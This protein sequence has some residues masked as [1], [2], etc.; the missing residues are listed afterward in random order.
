[1]AVVNPSTGL[2]GVFGWDGGIGQIDSINGIVDNT[3]TI[4]LSRAGTIDIRLSDGQFTI[5]GDVFTLYIDG[6]LVP[7]TTTYYWGSDNFNGVLEDFLLS[8]GTHTVTAF[9]SG[10]NAYGTITEFAISAVTYVNAPPSAPADGD[11]SAGATVYEDH[12]V[13]T[14]IGL[15]ANSTDPDAGDTVSY[16]LGFDVRGN[17]I[18]DNG[19]FA[20][21]PSTGVVTL[22]AALDYESAASH[23]LRIYA[24]DGEGASSFTD[25]NITVLDAIEGTPG[26][27][28]LLGTPNSDYMYGYGGHDL[29]RGNAGNDQLNGGDGDDFL[30]GGLGDDVIDG[31]AGSDR[32]AFYT[33][34]TAGVTVDLNIVGPQATG[35]GN[36]T[37][38]GIEN[39]SGTPYADTLIGDGNDN[40]LWGSVSALGDGTPTGLNNDTLD[41]GGGNDLLTVGTGAHLLT[42]GTGTDTVSF[43]ENGAAEPGVTVSLELEGAAQVTGAGSWTLNGIENLSG[44]TNNDN[45]TGDGNAN[46]LAGDAGDDTL[47]GKGGNDTLYGDGQISVD[48]HG[49]G[50][51]G[52]ITTTADTGAGG[53]DTLEGGLG[54]DQLHGGGGSD[55]ATYA[56]AAGVV[57][58]FLD[59]GGYGEAYGADGYDE[60][61]DIENLTG[62]AFNDILYGNSVDNFISGGDGHD[63]VRGGA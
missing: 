53:N 9:V 6:V 14:P 2:S 19:Q 31:G 63:D 33:D 39:V 4:T 8:A 25:F 16:C 57:Q 13:G 61:H 51:S 38:A 40:Q 28:M 15:D 7:W 26:N 18:L 12:P 62:G 17:P 32:A 34:A 37:L 55:T 44:G 56:N 42:G 3:W 54:D 59:D 30:S 10:P 21:D 45:L 1:M 43:T 41:G 35:Q 24:T 50:Y 27:D 46:V 11:G 52:P 49:L 23:V 47:S 5:P 22:S 58:A 29:L 48:S 60:L 20:I 36:D